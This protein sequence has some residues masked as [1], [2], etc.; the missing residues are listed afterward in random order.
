VAVS[1]TADLLVGL[2]V[3]PDRMAATL[4]AAGDAVLA[5]QRTMAEVAGHLPAPTYLGD[6]GRQVD[7][8]V[9]R[10]RLLLERER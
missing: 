1:Q 2:R 5:E 3:H 7:R 9:A 10:A 4:A 8:A 6:A